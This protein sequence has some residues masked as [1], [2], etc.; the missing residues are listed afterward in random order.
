MTRTQ[1]LILIVL[2]MAVLAV[3]AGAAFVLLRPGVQ[4]SAVPTVA[5]AT[6]PPDPLLLTRVPL[7]R[8]VIAR[9]L[10][11]RNLTG[12]A[13]LD[14]QGSR[15]EIRLDISASGLGVETE[16]PAGP[17][18]GAFEAALAGLSGN[19][20]GYTELRVL[21]GG[22]EALVGIKDLQAWELGAIDD[23]VLSGRVRLSQ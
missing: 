8:Q 18:W 22:Y 14:P 20:S 7:C 15:L 5:L 21:A 12:E 4:E 6:V 3:F 11:E 10:L 23:G 13:S 9:T 2:G 16:L 1:V 19:C 17:I